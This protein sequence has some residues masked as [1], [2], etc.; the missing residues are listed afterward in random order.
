MEHDHDEQEHASPRATGAE[1]LPEFYGAGYLESQPDQYAPR[2][3]TAAYRHVAVA[4]QFQSRPFGVDAT[5]YDPHYNMLYPPHGATSPMFAGA[6]SID[7]PLFYTGPPK[8]PAFDVF[9]GSDVP[10]SEAAPE[11]SYAPRTE[12]LTEQGVEI[13]L[14]DPNPVYHVVNPSFTSVLSPQ[15]TLYRLEQ[16]MLNL[17]F[18]YEKKMPWQLEVHGLL[19]AEE[20]TFRLSLTKPIDTPDVVQVDSYLL[21]GDEGHFLRLFDIIRS[22]CSAFDKDALEDTRRILRKSDAWL[23]IDAMPEVFPGSGAVSDDIITEY[24]EDFK[25]LVHTSLEDTRS[26]YA[27]LEMAKAIKNCV[28]VPKNRLTILSDSNLCKLFCETLQLMVIDRQTPLTQYAVFIVYQFRDSLESIKQWI[29]TDPFLRAMSKTSSATSNSVPRMKTIA[30][31]LRQ[32]MGA[33]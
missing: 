4:K 7:T 31:T 5:S 11:A 27:R 13:P 29:N 22:E 1:A 24:C 33:C 9:L 6:G 19:C 25:G 32:E 14:T 2:Q 26:C 20:V 10:S 28:L 23:N 15:D 17:E 30:R 3:P 12:G 18:A 8:K 16:V 21:E